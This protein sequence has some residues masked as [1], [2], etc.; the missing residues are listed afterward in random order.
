VTAGAVI[1]VLVGGPVAAHVSLEPPSMPKGGGG[2]LAFVVPN[3]E[4]AA[5]TVKV[6]V[7][8]PADHPIPLVLVAPHPGWTATSETTKLPTPVETQY[9]EVTEAVTR[10][11]W[12]GGQIAPGQFDRFVVLVASLP[13]DVATLEFKVVQ[14][15][16]N[17]DVVRWIEDPGPNGAPPDHPAPLLA[18]TGPAATVTPPAPSTS[19]VGTT[20]PR[21][22][23]QGHSATSTGETWAE[24]LS[25]L[26][27]AVAAVA[28]VV[29][30]RTNLAGR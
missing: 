20:A 8:F 24:V 11:T 21:L 9:G 23:T 10:V 25:G 18:L 16:S 19:T 15:Y 17:G 13:T 3:E 2:T 1:L 29:S 14:T 22:P 12:Q 5:A 30:I 26:A 27:L 4:T 6:D 28:L 7:A